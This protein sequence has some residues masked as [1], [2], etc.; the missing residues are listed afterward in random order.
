MKIIGEVKEIT[1]TQTQL[2]RAFGVSKQRIG[3]LIGEGIVIRDEQSTNGQVLLFE[4]VKN[5]FLHKNV[6]GAD[7]EVNYNI[8]KALYMKAKRELAELKLSK[9]R[10]ELYNA[11]DVEASFVNLLT[12]LRARLT[13][14]P[15]RFAAQL[16]GSSRE[17]IY[18]ILAN[19]IEECLV[20]LAEFDLSNLQNDVDDIEDTADENN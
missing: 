19:E 5:F 8:E 12:I 17:E 11:Q 14:L 7:A 9:A 1:C 16:E 13:G 6:G 3:Q 18:N 15:A 2:G 10:G 20:E 4:S